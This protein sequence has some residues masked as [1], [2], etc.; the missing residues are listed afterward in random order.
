MARAVPTLLREENVDAQQELVLRT[1]A[2]KNI[3]FVRLWFTDVLGGLK[4]VAVD[5]AELETAFAEGIGFDG[6]ALEALSRVFESDMLLRPDAATWQ[7]LPWRGTDDAVGRMFCD[8]QNPDGTP[9]RT[10]PRGVLERTLQ[11]AADLGFTFQVHPEIEFY[12][13]KPPS[14]FN[15]PLIP[16]DQA[17]YFDHV[18]RG[19]A[20][21][22]RR[23]AVMMLE[24]MGIPVEFSHHEDGP[25]QN[26]I[27]LRAVDA[28][29]AADN[30]MSFRAVI[31]EVALQEGM[32]AT[33]M[34]KP[35][36]DHPGS[37]MHVHL[38]LFEGQENAFYSAS[39]QY[40]LSATGR[41]FVAG[42]LRHAKEISAVT[43][44]HVNS[45]KRLWGG[46][47]A[48]AYICWG[49]N[50]RSALVRVP[51]YKPNLAHTARVEY[52]ALDSAA[53]PYLA[54]AVLLAAGLKGIEE[55]YDL[56]AE[57]EDNVWNLSEVERK[58]LGIEALPTSLEA[59]VRHLQDSELMASTLGEEVFDYFLRNKRREWQAYR[60]QITP[61]ELAAFIPLR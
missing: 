42:L 61:G 44:Q 41:S 60:R 43:N 30:I 20:N 57:A 28:L 49:H 40:Q 21:D 46:G 7:L 31:E 39:G 8:L 32:V 22:F 52:R 56:P 26:E 17:G 5:P 47:E 19:G 13:F 34:P 1:I 2:E 18:A 55:G 33:F 10:D 53:N 15:E 25:G 37:G 6:S 35:L 51:R 11:K 45:Y 59:A 38:S 27:D 12:L 14:S 4:S 24:E 23:R 16:V 36:V 54:F 3:R 29:T 48:P 50:N 58:A 9:A